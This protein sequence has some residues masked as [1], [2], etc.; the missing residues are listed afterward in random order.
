MSKGYHTINEV[1]DEGLASIKDFE[2]INYQEASMWFQKGYRDFQLFEAGAQVKEDW[3]DVTPINTVNFPEDLLRLIDAGVLID[4]EFFS[5]TRSDNLPIPSDPLDISLDT[6]KGEG[7]SINRSPSWGYGAKG[8]NLEYY[9]KEDRT[10]R[11][12]ILSRM[13][14]D[15]TLYA[16]RSQVLVRYIATGIDDYN[17]TYIA[18]DAANLLSSF[19]SYH[20]VFARP[21][22]YSL[23]YIANDESYAFINSITISP[24]VPVLYTLIK[25]FGYS[26]PS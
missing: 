22:I 23:G 5:F 8:N 12:I 6:D 10:A 14:L 25:A 24:P 11:R 16:D 15:K 21:E 9:Y 19:V 18:D 26:T 17:S 4:G 3:R 20:L 7:N 1:I 2:R 13:A